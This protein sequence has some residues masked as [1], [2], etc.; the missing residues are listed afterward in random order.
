MGMILTI[1]DFEVGRTKIALDPEQEIDLEEYIDK[2]EN[3]YLP[4]LFGKNLYDLFKF[5]YQNPPLTNRFQIVFAPFTFQ[6]D[7]VLIQ[8][9]GMTEMLKCFVYYLYLRDDVTRSTTIGLERVIGENTESV[10]AIGHDLT[11][12]YNEGVDAFQTIQYYMN[13]FDFAN[14]PEFN[15]VHLSYANI[16]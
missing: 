9:I 12:R 4:M 15:G 8:S 5:S 11:S 7:K 14:Y 13:T 3:T 1:D 16:Y 6:D 2:V 10:T